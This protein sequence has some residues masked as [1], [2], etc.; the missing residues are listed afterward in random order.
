MLPYIEQENV[1]QFQATLHPDSWWCGYTIK[2]YVSPA[3]FSAPADGYP[4]HV[5]PRYGTSYAPNEAVFAYG[6]TITPSW[7][8]GHVDPV[9]KMPATFI[10]GMSNT[11]VLAEKYMICGSRPGVHAAFYY[12]ETCLNCGSPGNY[13]GACNRQGPDTTYVGSP[14]MFYNSLILPPQDRPKVDNCNPCMLQAMH[15][16]GILVAMGDGSVRLVNASIS[17]TTW[18][19]A[20]NPADGNPLGPDW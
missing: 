10:D 11:I 3:D 5:R 14:P 17:Q 15:N 18:M 19:N 16:G 6:K 20:V 2:T 12:G 1:Y 13:H 7:R 9:A 8:G 4:D